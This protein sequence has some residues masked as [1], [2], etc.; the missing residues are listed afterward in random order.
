MARDTKL[1]RD[2]ALK[3]R[4]ADRRELFD[5]GV[6]NCVYAVPLKLE[7]TFAAG[8]PTPLFAVRWSALNNPRWR[9]AVVS[10]ARSA[11]G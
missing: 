10:R 6:D 11:C 3:I 8:A 5:L 1:R 9:F 7:P 2:V 4:P